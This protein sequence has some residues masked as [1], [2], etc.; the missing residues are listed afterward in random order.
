MKDLRS[1]LF[2][3]DIAGGE[4]PSEGSLLVA[5][6]FLRERYFNHAVICLVDYEPQS[7]AMGIV[8]NNPT[9]HTLQELIEGVNVKTPIP[10]FCGG[11]LSSNRLFF[12][13]TLGDLIPDSR[14]VRERLYIGGDFDAML[15]VVN[16]G[17]PI[18]GN[19]RFFIGYSGWDISQL[20]DEIAKNVWA[21][22][23]LP[24]FTDL[25]TDMEDSYWHKVVRRMGPAYRGWL[26]HPRNL[27]SN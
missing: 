8:L 2:N 13:H 1:A 10:V 19:F 24:H 4:K 20:D 18:E 22:A 5:E 17:Y 16:D 9:E 7:T 11:P 3:I 21:V 15:S 23:R 6:P 14:Q 26:F 12:M 25:L 27:S